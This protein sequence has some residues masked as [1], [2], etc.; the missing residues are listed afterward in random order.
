VAAVVKYGVIYADPPWTFATYS[1]KG[2][3]RSAEAHYDC[4]TI[5]QLHAMGPMID[6]LAAD[7]CV[8][9]MWV[10]DPMLPAGLLLI[11]SW[12]FAFKTVGFYWAKSLKSKAPPHERVRDIFVSSTTHPIGTGF[13][14]R[15]NPEVCL[16]ATRGKPK[17]KSG[18]VRKLIVSPRRAHSQKP[19]EMYQRIETLC[20]GPYVEL[21]G[22]SRREGWDSWGNEVDSGIGQ[23]R[24]R[25]DGSGL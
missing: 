24:W 9:L 16:L 4:M 8:L 21:F 22:R 23:R 15:S 18:G 19:D 3:G 5:E 25:S 14:T 2:R 17:R 6:E 1:R 11:S 7:D 20:T 13:W 12:G 10:T